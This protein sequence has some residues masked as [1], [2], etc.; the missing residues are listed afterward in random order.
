MLPFHQMGKYKWQ[1]LGMEYA[2]EDVE[3]P[4]PAVIERTC[5]LFRAEGLTT[6]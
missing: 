4:S 2:L 6:Y 5:A 3:P 1:Q